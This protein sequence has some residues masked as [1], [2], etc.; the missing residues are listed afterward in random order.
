ML[1]RK[2][3]L[4]PLDWEM[5]HTYFMAVEGQQWPWDLGIE[6]RTLIIFIFQNWILQLFTQAMPD[7][8]LPNYCKHLKLNWLL[9]QSNWLMFTY[10]LT[11]WTIAPQAPLSTGFSR[12]E[13]W[14]GLPFP[15]PGDLPNPVIKPMSPV[16]PAL[17]SRFFTTEHEDNNI[18][19]LQTW[20]C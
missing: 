15:P 5:G 18:I 7:I 12:Q 1:A 4:C 9:G 8:A 11:L 19:V 2:V 17:A 10:L 14:S 20:I 16:S 6:E 13:Y 3:K